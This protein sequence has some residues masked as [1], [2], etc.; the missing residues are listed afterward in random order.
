MVNL[1]PV[2]IVLADELSRLPQEVITARL[3]RKVCTRIG[4]RT[5]LAAF[6][7]ACF[8]VAA[9]TLLS[10]QHY[11][12]RWLSSVGVAQAVLVCVI[13]V[14]LLAYGAC[15]FVFWLNRKALRQ[16]L[17]KELRDA[18]VLICT[19]CGYN[20]TGLTQGTCP[21]C[22]LQVEAEEPASSR[23]DRK[24]ITPAPV[25]VLASGILL[26]AAAM[27]R[28]ILDKK[29]YLALWGTAIC[30][31]VMI[32]TFFVSRWVAGRKGTF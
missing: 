16:S 9:L 23:R 28:M 6:V 30:G 17:Y 32:A 21:E 31:L 11:V 3:M 13:P 20:T 14:F 19:F 2:R 10:R 26:I 22:G 25:L 1:N 12:Y 29:Q 15:I 27:A 5:L 4:H 8:I 18:G 7:V 24:K